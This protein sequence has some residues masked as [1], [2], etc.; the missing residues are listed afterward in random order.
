VVQG[1]IIF[2]NVGNS[3][4]NLKDAQTAAGATGSPSTNAESSD[5]IT[6]IKN[7]SEI[8]AKN[9]VGSG[10][11][12]GADTDGWV[13]IPKDSGTKA[14]GAYN[15]TCSNL[16]YS[17]FENGLWT[18]R[19]DHD[20]VMG[21]EAIE[22]FELYDDTYCIPRIRYNGGV[23][24]RI[25]GTVYSS[26]LDGSLDVD[27]FTFNASETGAYCVFEPG[28]G[29]ISAP[30]TCYVGGN[31][32]GTTE[33]ADNADVTKCPDG[34]YAATKVG[35]GGWRGKVGLLGVAGTSSDYRNVCFL[36]EITASPASLDTARNYYTYRN[37][38][39]E[40]INK[41][42]MCHDFLI[43]DGQPTDAK[44]F[45]VCEES[46]A[47]IGGFNLA[48]KNIERTISS[49]DNLLD[50]DIDTSSCLGAAG[51]SY[52][53]TGTIA[54]ATSAPTVTVTD[55]TN[56]VDCSSTELQ[57]TCNITTAATG[58][59]FAGVYNSQPLSCSVAPI[60]ATGCELA[61]SSSSLPTYK[62]TG[63]I[64][65]TSAEQVAAVTLSVIDDVNTS[66]CIINNDW[67]STDNDATYY[68]DI[69]TASTT[70][71][72]IDASVA[73]GFTVIP[74]SK[75]APDLSGSGCTVDS[76][77]SIV[78]AAPNFVVSNVSTFT[79]SG[80]ITLGGDIVRSLSIGINPGVSGACTMTVPNQ[81]WKKSTSGSYECVLTTSGSTT[82]TMSISGNTTT[83]TASGTSAWADGQLIIDLS[84]VSSAQVNNISIN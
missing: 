60:S 83:V 51:T 1:E 15:D 43:I 27:L 28:S 26:E 50:P 40:G 79:L 41:S 16:G 84:N 78:V 39:N 62:I 61:F 72:T 2:D 22:L 46:E 67:N 34:Y 77:C 14:I 13:W 8:D 20:G 56:T 48:S 19:V 35:A 76:P 7:I 32:T 80:T 70:G 29:S 54:N 64:E 30:Y 18:K 23:I 81:G 74:A 42:Y 44:V 3:A 6:Q 10:S 37:G 75:S 49:G 55:G 21:N 9:L 11:F 17:S 33:G 38:I 25:S 4:K 36:E 59:T 58:L 53:I 31:C 45:K 47:T 82:V 24:L 68:C 71:L 66:L 65:A 52:T 63:S 69:S 57:Y 12:V 73:D 5:E